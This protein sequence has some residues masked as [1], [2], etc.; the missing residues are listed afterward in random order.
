MHQSQSHLLRIRHR[1]V[2]NYLFPV[3]FAPHRLVLRPREG[4]DLRVENMTLKISP[5]STLVWTRD[6]FGNSVAMVH[7]SESAN[8]LVIDSDVEVRRFYDPNLPPLLEQSASPYPFA[9]D[10]LE[11][12]IMTGYLTPLYP[13]DA[14]DLQNWIMSLPA[15]GSFP[16]AEAFT[17]RLCEM[18]H[19]SIAYQ[20]RE[21]KGV[22]NPAGTLALGSGSC[23]DF[24]TLMMETLRH[25]GIAARFVS[26]Y[27]DCPATRAAKGSTHAWVEVYFP[28]LG[29]RGFD[30][31][32]GR[33]C[34][35]RHVVIGASHHPR[36][37]MPISGDFIGA[38]NA[39]QSM[40]VSVEFSELGNVGEPQQQQQQQQ[41]Q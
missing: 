20:R 16:S 17:V 6:I 18:I 35:H 26:G 37:V 15:P 23:R 10:S 29:W 38:T 36:G 25:L 32:A 8:Q 11:Q 33:V 27:L 2:Y 4:H 21:Q 12:G 14:A 22:Q 34:D 28:R 39:F 7:F 24:A 9:Y 3:N 41:Q 1:T 30:S 19:E 5:A 13:E 40:T 31:T